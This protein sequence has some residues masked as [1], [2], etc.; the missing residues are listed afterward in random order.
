MAKRDVCGKLLSTHVDGE[1]IADVCGSRAGHGP[2]EDPLDTEN[3]VGR[4]HGI[5]WRQGPGEQPIILS[6]QPDIPGIEKTAEP[7]EAA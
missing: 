3:H 7:G 6:M 2:S 4:W 1:H 5:R